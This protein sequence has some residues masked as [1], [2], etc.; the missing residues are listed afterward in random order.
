[1]SVNVVLGCVMIAVAAYHS[2]RLAGA[3]DDRRHIDT[4]IA[5][6]AMG[7]AMALMLLGFLGPG[8]SRCWALAM[9][10]PAAWFACRA[11]RRYIQAGPRAAGHDLGQAILCAAM[12]YMLAAPMDMPGHPSA[13]GASMVMNAGH[14]RA[15]VA[16]PLLTGAFIAST[17]LVGLWTCVRLRG[18][19]TRLTGPAPATGAACRLAMIGTTGYMLAL[20]L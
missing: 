14:G 12:L 15:G 7:I 17:V 19:A 18:T 3:L 20:M 4:D 13:H 6:A 9:V 1:M 8:A 2:L 5:H 10:L 11:V 16:D